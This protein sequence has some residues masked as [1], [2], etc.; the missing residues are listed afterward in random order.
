MYPSKRGPLQRLAFGG[1]INTL[2]SASGRVERRTVGR[3]LLP[4]TSRGGGGPR[5]AP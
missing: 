3:Q 4:I 1:G 2:W 5:K